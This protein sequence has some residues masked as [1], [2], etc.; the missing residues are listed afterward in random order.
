MPFGWNNKPPFSGVN[1]EGKS[2]F[3]TPKRG[4]L[5][6]NRAGRIAWNRRAAEK[7]IKIYTYLGVLLPLFLRL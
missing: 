2:E 1:E 6:S 5:I 4:L 7:S 3:F